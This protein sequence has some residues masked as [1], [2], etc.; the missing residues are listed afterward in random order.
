MTHRFR[1]LSRAET[2]IVAC[3]TC[4]AKPGEACRRES[5]SVHATRQA[6]A[7]ATL[8]RHRT[9]LRDAQQRK[10]EEKAKRVNRDWLRP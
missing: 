1:P 8:T 3:P 10:A 2:I 6:A 9:G 4:G 7:R 5:G